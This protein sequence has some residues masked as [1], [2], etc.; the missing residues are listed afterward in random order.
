[1]AT[2]TQTQP[3]ALSAAQTKRLEAAGEKVWRLRTGEAYATRAERRL[4]RK[5]RRQAEA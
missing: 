5:A 4:A 3:K 1:M 2:T